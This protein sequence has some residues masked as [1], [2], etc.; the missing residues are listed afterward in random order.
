MLK[1]EGSAADPAPMPWNTVEGWVVFAA[2]G[3]TGM[4]GFLYSVA[5]C[6]RNETQI[7]DLHVRVADLRVAYQKRLLALMEA[8]DAGFITPGPNTSKPSAR[9]AERSGHGHA[10]RA[11]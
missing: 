11:A 3:G 10:K 1:G 5:S 9:K 8:A 7:H 2:I 4:L 6:M